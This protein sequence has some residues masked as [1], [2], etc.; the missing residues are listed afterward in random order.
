MD[1]TV[2][3]R[4][5]LKMLILLLLKLLVEA[6]A[7]ALGHAQGPFTYFFPRQF[8][9]VHNSLTNPFV[10][11][12]PAN[13]PNSRASAETTLLIPRSSVRPGVIYHSGMHP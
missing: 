5:R 4:W 11:F 1:S 9:P 3:S 7:C 2:N 13:V 8:A 10:S 6:A 12:L